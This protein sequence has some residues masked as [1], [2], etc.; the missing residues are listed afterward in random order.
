MNFVLKGD[1]EQN[2]GVINGVSDVRKA[3]RQQSKN[4]ADLIKI[5]ATGGVLSVAKSG[6]NAK[7]FSYMVEAG[8]SR[9]DA[10]FSATKTASELVEKQDV[11]GTIEKGKIADIIAV[12]GNPLQKIEVLEEVVFVMKNGEIYKNLTK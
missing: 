11:L 6:E 3:V 1:P 10:I 4:G 7:E 5:A 12:S 2:Q 8:M 9:I